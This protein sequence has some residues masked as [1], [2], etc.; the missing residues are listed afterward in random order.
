MDRIT[1]GSKPRR[2][3]VIIGIGLVNKLTKVKCCMID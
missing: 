1:G 2:R 3:D